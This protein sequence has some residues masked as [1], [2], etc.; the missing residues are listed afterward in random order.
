MPAGAY[1]DIATRAFVVSMKSPFGG[2]STA[3]V[4]QITGLSVRQ[5]NRIYGRAIERGFEPNEVP[6][7][8]R[9]AFLQDRPRTGRPKLQTP[10]MIESTAS[11]VRASKEG[12]ALTCAD[13]AG[14]LS[15]LG[16]EI[17]RETVR[18]ALKASGFRKS[19]PTRKPGLTAAMRKKRLDWCL[20][21]KDWGLDDWKKVIWTDETSVLLNSRK[22][23]YRVWRTAKERFDRTC[24]R[25][26]WKG[27]SEFMFWG[28]F[29]YDSKG[30]GYCWPPETP[31]ERRQAAADV[32]ELNEAL[33]EEFRLEWEAIT[34][35][36][37]LGLR[38]RPGKK[39]TW[40]WNARSGKLV[41]KGTGGIDWY[42]YYTHILLPR[43]IPFAK[44]C[45]Q[46]RPNTLVQEDN[47]PAHAHWFQRRVYNAHDVQRM[48]W[49]GN[50]PDLNAIEC[51]WGWLKRHTTRKGR[52]TIRGDA[53]KAWE[54]SWAELPQE[55]IQG[56]IARIPDHVQ[57]IIRIDGGNEYK[58]G[59]QIGVVA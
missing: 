59:R 35:I 11:I 55:A 16:I 18:R 31:S 42:R 37:R 4:A 9:D 46:Q 50:S 8:I 57:E 36:S 52:H 43:L 38:T 13:I 28:A 51:A 54:R 41:R 17:S 12:R 24:V 49:P 27:F 48:L 44:R 14:E 1:T 33:E 7:V 47:A 3:E 23:G 53:V 58:E 10:Q 29:P 6:L 34:A 32:E 21:R 20:E 45:Q 56:W 39:P 2:K 22:G 40:R 5:V 25:P 19:K 30:P 15:K 26:R